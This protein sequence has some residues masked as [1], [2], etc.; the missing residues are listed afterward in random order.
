MQLFIT[1]SGTLIGNSLSSFFLKKKGYKIISTYNKSFPKNLKNIKNVSLK[2][3]DLLDNLNFKKK[4]DVLI[5]CASAI[6]DY[7]FD[8]KKINQTNVSGFKKILSICKKNE[9]KKIILLSTMDVY[10]DIQVNKVN[11]NYIG[12]KVNWYGKSKKKM[13]DLLKIYCQKNRIDGFIFRLPGVVGKNSS[14][15]FLS[16]LMKKIKKNQ[17]LII[18]NPKAMFNNLIHVKNLC[19][20]VEQILKKKGIKIYNLGTKKPLKIAD[21]VKILK[22]NHK[23]SKIYCDREIKNSFTININKALRDDLKLFSTKKSLDLFRQENIR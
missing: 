11:E 15:N 19:S 3:L 2:K 4:F 5:H 9:C 10:G 21:V 22:K 8:K 12:K 17:N 20:I 13:E 18:Y 14:H 23:I 7:N 16:N 1:G 6:P